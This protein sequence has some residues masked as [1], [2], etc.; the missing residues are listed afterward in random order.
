MCMMY[1]Y[2]EFCVQ[3]Y[4][5]VVALIV[6]GGC[7]LVRSFVCEFVW[8]FDFN[9]VYIFSRENCQNTRLNFWNCQNTRYYF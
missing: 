8:Y 6:R 5:V 2:E 1:K 4:A 3:E 9:F 7:K